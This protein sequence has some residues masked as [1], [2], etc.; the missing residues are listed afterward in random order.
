MSAQL[1]MPALVLHAVGD[2]RYEQVPIPALNPGEALVKVAAVG[3]CGSDIPRI[4][5]H[6]TYRFPL[7]PGHELAGVIEQVAEPATHS[8][9]KRVTV[10][11]LIPCYHCAYCEIGAYGQCTEYDYLGSRRDG[12]FAAYVTVPQAN[13]VPIPD[14]VSLIDAAL[15]EPAAVALHALRQG[16]I[17]PGDVVAILGTGPIGMLLA[18]WARLWGAGRVLLVDIDPL[19]LQVAEQLGLGETFNS[20]TVDPIAWV[21]EQSHGS[22]GADLVVEAAGA[23]ITFRQALHMARPLGTVVLMGNPAGNVTLPQATV[24]QILRKQ[25]TIRGTWNSQFGELP[26]DEWQVVLSMAATGRI[27]LA[28]MIS[29]R[30]PLAQGIEAIEMM[31]DRREFYNRVILVNE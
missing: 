10:K 6:G 24:S 30:M 31:R 2:L 9:G 7:I 14:E 29:H 16:G 4:Y 8:P 23:G 28:P 25:L 18:Q 27:K 19:K 3:V 15:T 21:L 11:P 12:G 17:Q 5:E 22:R 20:R 26:V 13:L 1:T